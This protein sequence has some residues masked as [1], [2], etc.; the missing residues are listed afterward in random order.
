MKAK[1]AVLPGDG[2]GP[3]ITEQTLR[4]MSAIGTRFNHEFAT[5][6]ALI[7]GI[8]IDKTGDPFP[9]ETQRTCEESDAIL[10]AA[11]GGPQWS[12]PTASVRP[13]QGLLKMRQVF[14]LF[15]NL[16]PVKT[17]PALAEYAPLRA[18]LLQ[19]VD[20]LFVRELT[21]GIYFGERQEMGDGD[22]CLRH[23]ALYTPRG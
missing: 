11:V 8:A 10:L 5:E 6:E 9:A 14:G 7:G 12:D 19:D 4:V 3:E 15:A 21:G 13:E 18:D 16:R 22:S 23:H 2:I 17:Y 20:I 1:I